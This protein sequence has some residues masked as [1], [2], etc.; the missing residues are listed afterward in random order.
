ME[1]SEKAASGQPFLAVANPMRAYKP[2]KFILSFGKFFSFS[3]WRDQFAS[4]AT[5]AR[6]QSRSPSAASAVSPA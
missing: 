5:G 6:L 4:S 1:T 2:H 3:L